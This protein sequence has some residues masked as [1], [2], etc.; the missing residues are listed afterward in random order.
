MIYKLLAFSLFI[1]S[2]IALMW[3]RARAFNRTT[4]CGSQEFSGYFSML[5]I[6]VIEFIIA[7]LALAVFAGGVALLVADYMGYKVI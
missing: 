7:T 3:L 6:R 4:H 1:V 2:I 5:K